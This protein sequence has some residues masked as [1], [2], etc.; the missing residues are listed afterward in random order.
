MSR[1]RW[2]SQSSV[3]GPRVAGMICLQDRKLGEKEKVGEIGV[4]A[5][6]CP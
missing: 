5:V 4:D 6:R 2:T 3:L 1:L